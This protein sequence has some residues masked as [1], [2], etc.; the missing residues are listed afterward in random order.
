MDEFELLAEQK[1]WG[2]SKAFKIVIEYGF[3]MSISP[4]MN[5]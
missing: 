5:L 2:F 1:L 4:F 3:W